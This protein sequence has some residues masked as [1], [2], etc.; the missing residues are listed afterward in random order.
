MLAREGTPEI[1]GLKVSSHKLG[2]RMERK[3][4]KGPG[5]HREITEEKE[6]S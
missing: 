2:D 1:P 6:S 5:V 4:E 3:E